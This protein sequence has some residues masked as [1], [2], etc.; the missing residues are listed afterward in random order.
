MG[1]VANRTT[2]IVLQAFVAFTAI[3]GAVFVVPSLPLDWIKAGPMT[4]FTIPAIALGLCGLAAA[5]ALV[6]L[7]VEPR[8]GGAASV[9]AGALMIAF[10]IV[11][12]AVV[13]FAPVVHGVEYPQSWLQIVYLAIGAITVVL[14]YRLWASF[15]HPRAMAHPA[16]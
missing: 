3:V 2:L 7:V 5:V 12:I 16:H 15:A 8:L 11:E 10:E 4:D 13:G 1:H 9:V 14:G 6:L